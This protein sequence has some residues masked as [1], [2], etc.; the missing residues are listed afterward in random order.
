MVKN[1]PANAG[2]TRETGLTPGLGRSL[3]GG[4]GNSL[5]FSCLRNPVD[6]GAWWATFHGLAKESDMTEQLKNNVFL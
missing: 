5:Q 4:N 3:R 1:L 2:D 6:R